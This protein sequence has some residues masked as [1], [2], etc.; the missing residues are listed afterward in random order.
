MKINQ[1]YKRA[2]FA[3]LMAFCMSVFI[4]FILVSLNNG[5][6]AEFFSAW[7]KTWCE[8]FVCAFFGAYYFP[9]VINK[10]LMN[11]IPFEE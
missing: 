11:K 7:L 2:I 9:V 10:F 4:S 5:Y 6:N 1:K 3:L 8:A